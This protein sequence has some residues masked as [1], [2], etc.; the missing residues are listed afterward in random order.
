MNRARD[1]PA[2]LRAG[3]WQSFIELALT[4]SMIN[5]LS[6]WANIEEIVKHQINSKKVN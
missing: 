4:A 5:S 6:D 2:A 1:T 3:M